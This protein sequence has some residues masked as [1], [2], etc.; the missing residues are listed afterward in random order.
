MATPWVRS[1]LSVSVAVVL[2]FLLTASTA[3]GDRLREVP[4]SLLGAFLEAEKWHYSPEETLKVD[5]WVVN[6]ASQTLTV[7]D[8]CSYDGKLL[9]SERRLVIAT[10]VRC[11]RI[12][13]TAHMIP[14]GGIAYLGSYALPLNRL[15]RDSVP[16]DSGVYTLQLRVN[17]SRPLGFVQAETLFCVSPTPDGC[18]TPPEPFPMTQTAGLLVLGT[19]LGLIVALALLMRVVG[20]R[21]RG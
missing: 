16:L 2:L 15:G 13:Q 1:F 21:R 3:T 19:A 8:S 14:P 6:R 12:N 5:I 9:D 7:G 11:L 10:A 20:S 17:L 18:P 4:D